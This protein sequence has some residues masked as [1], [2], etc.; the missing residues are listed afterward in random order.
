MRLQPR[1]QTLETWR[2]VA[3]YSLQNEE[4]T[5]GG[6]DGRN[7]ISDAEQLL[8]V[9]YPAT[10]LPEFALENPD[11]TAVDV[12]EV[13][14]PFGDSVTIPK[15]LIAAI[16]DYMATYTSESG[17]PI[18]SGG[19]YF[20][21]SDPTTELTEDQRGFDVVSSF[22][23][24]ISLTLATLGFLKVF[25]R[26][27]TRRDLRD[28]IEALEEATSIRLTAAMIGLLRSFC[29]YT[30][31]PFSGSGRALL[32]TMNQSELPSRVVLDDLRHRMR[33]VR[34][35][36]REAIVGMNRDPLDTDERMLFECGW[37]WGVVQNAPTV[38]TTEPVGKQPEGVAVAAPYLHFTVIAL[39]GIGDLFSDRTRVLGLLNLEQQRLSTALQLRWDVAVEYWSQ[40]ARFGS[41]RW[42]LEDVPWRTTDGEE[43]TYFSLLVTAVVLLDLL[44]RRATERD[45]TRTIGVLETLA[46]LGRVNLRMSPGDPAATLH[47]PGVPITLI[48]AETIGPKMSWLADDYSALLLKHTT[49]AAGLSRG[50][51]DR[52]RLLAVAEDALT[53]LWKLRLTQGPATGL[54]GDPDGLT[55]SAKAKRPLPSWH[56]TERMIDALVTAATPTGKPPEP[57]HD[58]ARSDQGPAQSGGLP[59]QPGTTRFGAP[60]RWQARNVAG[61]RCQ[62]AAGSPAHAGE[63][64]YRARHRGGSAA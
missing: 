18:F 24:S 19:T 60:G 41:G 33:P 44:R 26:T 11:A 2:S 8:C 34:A 55:P 37:S 64:G 22:S 13:L 51:G 3:E 53:H 7:S 9:L 31:D 43:S 48:G 63:P 29:V 45:L 59:A 10:Q 40:I 27:V 16:A 46:L 47:H 50:S 17:T 57:Q 56:L 54:W 52:E 61:D 12:L 15:T 39:D 62:P 1:F 36:L 38:D 28:E 42:P 20:H 35:G 14:R 30:F 23:T 4:W 32:R 58:P 25:G 5:W 21:P 49:R 6:R